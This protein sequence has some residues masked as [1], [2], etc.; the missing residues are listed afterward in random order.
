MPALYGWHPADNVLVLTWC[1][2]E[3]FRHLP[4]NWLLNSF[5]NGST[6]SSQWLIQCTECERIGA[7]PIV[8]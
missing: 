1:H 5:T 3:D 8:K 7:V 2:P 6:T 4:R